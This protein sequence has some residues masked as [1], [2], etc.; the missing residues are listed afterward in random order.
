MPI[1]FA[2]G[3]NS[4]LVCVAISGDLEDVDLIE[5]VQWTNRETAF[6]AGLPILYDCSGLRTNSAGLT[7]VQM[8]LRVA[9][10]A[11]NRMA[12]VGRTPAA[13]SLALL[14]QAS[15]DPGRRADSHVFCR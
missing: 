7:L 8:I 2:A 5:L 3:C 6:G 14:Y 4:G 9:C 11:E 15:S 10:G 1:T 12:F 13:L